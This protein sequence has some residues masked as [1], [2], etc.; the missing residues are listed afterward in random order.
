MPWNPEKPNQRVP[1]GDRSIPNVSLVPC[2]SI[3]AQ[4][5]TDVVVHLIRKWR[6]QPGLAILGAEHQMQVNRGERLG[7]WIVPMAG[8]QGLTPLAINGNP[9]GVKTQRP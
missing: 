3:S 2:T 9:V 7:H 5:A 4:S 8:S 6:S 1:T